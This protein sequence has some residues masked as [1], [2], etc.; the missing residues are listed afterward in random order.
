M[1]SVYSQGCSD[2]APAVPVANIVGLVRAAGGTLLHNDKTVGHAT[3]PPSRERPWRASALGGRRADH[4]ERRPPGYG[5]HA[6]A[7]RAVR[8]LIRLPVA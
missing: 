6:G 7:R 3:W 4:A 5:N 8:E 2:A 1:F